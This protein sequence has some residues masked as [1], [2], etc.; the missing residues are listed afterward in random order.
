MMQ[1]TE[2]KALVLNRMSSHLHQ[3]LFKRLDSEL[4]DLLKSISNSFSEVRR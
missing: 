2:K 3:I 4:P 1:A